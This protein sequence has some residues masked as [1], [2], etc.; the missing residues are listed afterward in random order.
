MKYTFEIGKKSTVK[1]TIKLTEKE[2]NMQ[3]VKAESGKLAIINLKRYVVD[4]VRWF[5][6][7]LAHH[8]RSWRNGRRSGFKTRRLWRKGSSPLLRT[9]MLVWRNWQTR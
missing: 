9:N 7:I 8:L 2:W 5:E 6:S 3:A 1:L 4:N